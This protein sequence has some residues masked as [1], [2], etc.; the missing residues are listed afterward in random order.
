MSLARDSLD[1]FK[2]ALDDGNTGPLA[3]M[4]AENFIFEDLSRE[5]VLY[6]NRAIMS[7]YFFFNCSKILHTEILNF[8]CPGVTCITI[9]TRISH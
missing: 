2:T 5:I 4:L 1:K 6:C 9:S 7:Q 3:E 8:Q